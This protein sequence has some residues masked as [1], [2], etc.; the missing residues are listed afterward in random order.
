MIPRIFPVSEG[1]VPLGV[2]EHYLRSR[3]REPMFAG[4]DTFA[5]R[6]QIANFRAG[7]V[8][9]EGAAL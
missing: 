1:A 7:R 3:L 8:V 6:Q 4:L 2:S 5:D 9:F